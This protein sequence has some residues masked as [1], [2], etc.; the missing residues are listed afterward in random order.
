MNSILGIRLLSAQGRETH[1]HEHIIKSETLKVI[2]TIMKIET[3]AERNLS[4]C[5]R[6]IVEIN[7]VFFAYLHSSSAACCRHILRLCDV[8]V[9]TEDE[10]QF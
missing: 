4:E 1:E 2:I 10:F 8:C 6:R 7:L 5:Q 3:S 9:C